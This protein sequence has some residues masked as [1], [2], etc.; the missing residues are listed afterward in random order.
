MYTAPLLSNPDSRRCAINASGLIL[1]FPKGR[2]AV[3]I[4]TIVRLEGDCNY[5][6]F[7]FA[8]GSHLFVAVTLK[9]LAPRLPAGLFHRVHRKHLVN[10]AYIQTLDAPRLQLNLTTGEQIDVARRRL[11]V[12]R[13]AMSELIAN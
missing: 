10:R 7:W 13:E 2:K 8:D 6:T 5:T 12:A 4:H 11:A 9:K 3:P 1:P